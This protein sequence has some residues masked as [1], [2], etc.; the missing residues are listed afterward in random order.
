M[1]AVLIAEYCG[2]QFYMGWHLYYRQRADGSRNDDGEWG[3]IRRSSLLTHRIGELL[4]K[5]DPQCPKIQYVNNAADESR[6]WSVLVDWFAGRFPDGVPISI[7]RI[8]CP[9]V[10]TL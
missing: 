4:S 10:M 3:W 5:I 9:R 1:Q 2:G 8:D 7:D 6:Q